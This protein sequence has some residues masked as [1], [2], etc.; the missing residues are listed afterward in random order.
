MLLSLLIVHRLVK[1]FCDG[2]KPTDAAGLSHELEIPV[3]LV[4][5][6][7]YN[8]SESGVLSEARNSGK[9]SAYQPAID[10]EK[11]TIKFV[12]DRLNTHGTANVPVAQSAQLD[13]LS[14]SLRRFDETL[15]KS[16]ANILLKN[17]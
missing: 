16:P 8:L 6:I 9:E 11:M 12:M 5:H 14:D 10:V 13:K 15:E 1:K 3:R 4:R 2:E 7:L 17:L